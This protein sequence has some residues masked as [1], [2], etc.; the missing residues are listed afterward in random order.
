[1]PDA[2]HI[3][4]IAPP[5]AEGHYPRVTVECPGV[6]D[7]CR[8]WDECMEAG[9]RDPED[10][11]LDKLCNE[12]PVHGVV[13]ERIGGVGWCTPTERCWPQTTDVA[14][15]LEGMEPPPGR[16]TFRWSVE[17]DEYIVVHDLQPA[18]DRVTA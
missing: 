11:V 13:H 2:T 16:Y 12:E 15:A 14:E 17:D 3:L 4:V 1:M 5:I 18:P 9:C 8:A 10:D 6:T 7:S